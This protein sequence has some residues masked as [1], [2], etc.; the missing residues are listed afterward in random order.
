L[1]IA[2][3][4]GADLLIMDEPTTGLDP[5]FR[6]EFLGLLQDVMLDEEKTVFL[7]THIMSDLSS[8][9]DYITF[10]EDGK[11][12]FS[13]SVH[14]LEEHYAIVRG[15]VDLLDK[16][17]EQFFLSINKQDSIFEALTSN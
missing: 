3:S 14:D 4:H 6:R 2:L 8:I 10:I 1:A 9:A 7:S 16:D 13:K 17:T 11:I 5:M 15:G 12:V